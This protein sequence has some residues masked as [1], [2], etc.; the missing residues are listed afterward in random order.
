M[1]NLSALDSFQ[2][3]IFVVRVMGRENAASAV[4]NEVIIAGSETHVTRLST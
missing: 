3:T 4:F 2:V 1:T